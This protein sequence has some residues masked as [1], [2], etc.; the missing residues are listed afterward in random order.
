MPR[1]ATE[2][3]PVVVI[4]PPVSPEP[5]PTDVTVPPPP[6]VDAIVSVLP[7]GVIVTLLPADR[8]R[9]PASV[10]TL[11]TLGTVA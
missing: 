4:G 3:V 1:G 9:S 10:F 11:V 2:T 7:E 5:V 6:P 8:V